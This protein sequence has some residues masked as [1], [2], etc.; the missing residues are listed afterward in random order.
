MRSRACKIGIL[1]MALVL[2]AEMPKALDA[3]SSA[4]VQ[5]PAVASQ[6]TV[7]EFSVEASL[8][9]VNVLVTDEDGRVIS[10]L[11][12]D[13]FRLLDNGV[14]QKISG[15]APSTAPITIVML[16]EYSARGYD[17]YAAKAASWADRFLDKLE[18]R[19]WVALVTYDMNST[20]RVDFTRNR[21]SVRDSLRSL[22]FPMFSEANLFDA[23][24]ETL[25]KL[26]PVKGRKSV[27]LL[28][29]GANTFG[30]ANLDDVMN[31]LRRSDVTV[32]SIGLA[33]EEYTR[34][35]NSSISYLQARSFLNTFSEQTG[36]IAYFPRFAAE[37]PDNFESITGFLRNEYTLTF[38]PNR[39]LRHGKFHKLTVQVVRPDGKRMTVKDEKGRERKLTVFARS[40]YTA[41]A[42]PARQNTGGT[43]ESA[44]AGW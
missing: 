38:T 7:P 1:G 11:T 37:I 34:S 10:G 17:Y 41:P 8:V 3:E 9:N 39:E 12:Q 36:G 22:G 13:N 14:P 25:D 28:T 31:R 40:G 24:I 33:E 4:R 5:P 21:A 42:G 15:F 16:L 2:I 20:V 18:P 35:G 29:T 27:L 26:E 6:T 32:F 44:S 23:L 43:Q 19:D 30:R